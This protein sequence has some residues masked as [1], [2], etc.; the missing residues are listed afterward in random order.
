MRKLFI[1]SLV[2]LSL[3]NSNSALAAAKEAAPA[4]CKASIL[5]EPLSGDVLQESNAHQPLPT[6][7]MIKMLTAYVTMKKVKDGSVKLDDVV[8]VSAYA[9]RIGGSQVY[10]AQNEQFT[11]QQLLE[12]VM[13]QSANDASTAIAEHIGGDTEGFVQMMNEQAAALGMKETE[14][15][16]PHGLPPEKGDLP[17]LSSAYDM[18][19][20]GRAIIH[21]FP[22]LVEMSSRV[23][24]GFRE[25]KFKMQNHNK[26][27][28]SLRGCDGIKTGF[29][30]AAGYCITA[31]AERGGTRM[32]AVNMGCPSGKGRN[33]ETARLL[34]LGFTQYKTVK[35]MEA[36]TAAGK[37][38]PV[39]SG[40]L[41]EVKPVAAKE[42][43]AALKI[44]DRDKVVQKPVLCSGFNAPVAA[45]TK[46]GY[47]AFMLGDK[48]IARVDMLIK[49]EIKK[50]DF[51]AK[52]MRLL[53]LQ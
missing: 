16:S 3:I 48:E 19:L 4:L 20:L 24:Q 17:D 5:M 21:D 22:E 29:Y 27:L 10:L 15:H 12:A 23:E 25:D 46:C 30:P 18:A 51:E 34:S 39:K 47:T 52:V 49:D 36:G 42:V 38:V 41:E 7:S 45:G 8:T 40:M 53:H 9:S 32:L 37:A 50:L 2:A 6:A 1:L 13:I 14:V 33:A 28:L 26:L 11:L 44:S 43:N 35:L 31:T